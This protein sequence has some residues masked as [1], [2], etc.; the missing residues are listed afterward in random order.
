M[1]CLTILEQEKNIYTHNNMKINLKYT[2]L[3]STLTFYTY[4]MKDKYISKEY[5]N[6]TVYT[7]IHNKFE[8]K[9]K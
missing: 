2:N 3:Y 4:N 5:A 7:L 9:T 8:R 6:N 1:N